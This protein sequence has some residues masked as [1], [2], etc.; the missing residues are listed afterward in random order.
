MHHTQKRLN[1]LLNNPP[2]Q[3]RARNNWFNHLAFS[4]R[5]IQH[6]LF[7]NYKLYYRR[8]GKWHLCVS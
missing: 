3:K 5:L 1:K 4:A 7:T 6:S 2:K 8:K